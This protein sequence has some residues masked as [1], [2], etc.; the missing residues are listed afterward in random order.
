MFDLFAWH[1]FTKNK[2]KKKKK[3][4]RKKKK[5]KKA[6]K[7]EGRKKRR[8]ERVTVS[9]FGWNEIQ[10]WMTKYRQTKKKRQ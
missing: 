9:M 5:K 3:K 2:K 6:R 4:K 7:K 1:V 10:S 8:G